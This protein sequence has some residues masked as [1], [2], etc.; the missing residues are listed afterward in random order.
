MNKGTDYF[1][2]LEICPVSGY[3]MRPKSWLKR[4]LDRTFALMGHRS[5]MPPRNLLDFRMKHGS[6]SGLAAHMRDAAREGIRKPPSGLRMRDSG[7]GQVSSTGGNSNAASQEERCYSNA[8]PL[9][10]QL[11][12]VIRGEDASAKSELSQLM[13]DSNRCMG[14]DI[15]SEEI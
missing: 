15:F 12:H 2:D 5:E 8:E 3:R 13:D 6:F 1:Y 14:F 11:E 4:S 10:D 9:R 7:D